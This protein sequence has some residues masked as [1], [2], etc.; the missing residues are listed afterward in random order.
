MVPNALILI[1]PPPNAPLEMSA[2]SRVQTASSKMEAHVS[3]PRPTPS[4]T[5]NAALTRTLVL[6]YLIFMF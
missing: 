5:E 6:S 2:A 4:V 1:M 3:A